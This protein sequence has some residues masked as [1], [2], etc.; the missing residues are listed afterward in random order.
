[1]KTAVNYGADAVFIGGEAFG[2]RAKA[3]NFGH[4][5]MAEG[6]RYAHEHGVKV[7][8]TANILAHNYDL[9]G[10]REYFHELKELKPDALII[11]DP[12]MFMMAKEICPEIEIHV[13]TQA[14][15][16]N[17]HTFNFWYGLGAKRVV[18]A[19]ELSLNEIAD[20]SLVWEPV[21]NG[22]LSRIPVFKSELLLAVPSS[23]PLCGSKPFTDFEHI[24]YIDMDEVSSLKDFPF[25]LTSYSRTKAIVQSFIDSLDFEPIIKEQTSVWS[26]LIDYVINGERITLIDELECTSNTVGL[27][28]LA[29]YRIRNANLDHSVVA[30]FCSGK[31][32][33][34]AVHLFLD[35][36]KAYPSIASRPF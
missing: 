4:D 6:I 34:K 19:R 33:S 16:T 29:F 7:Y 31:V 36:L 17:Y 35:E 30:C 11:A 3:K 13:S 2:L 28:N 12:G 5:E 1:M 15:N 26:Y 18:A 27:Q 9:E 21:A 14:N 8:V 32:L 22:S 23:N 20:I 24:P 10:A 25:S